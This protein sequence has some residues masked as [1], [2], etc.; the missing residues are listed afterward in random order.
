M[1]QKTI[2]EIVQHETFAPILYLM[3]YSG[4]VENAID[5]QNGVAQGLSSAIMTNEMKEAEKILI[6]MLV[7]IVVLPM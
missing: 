2:Y 7:L 5:I 3:K 1:K 4:D 6:I